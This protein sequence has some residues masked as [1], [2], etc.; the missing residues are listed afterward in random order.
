MIRAEERYGNGD[1]LFDRG[2][3]ESRRWTALYNL[4][5]GTQNFTG[6]PRRCQARLEVDF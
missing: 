1:H 6:T 3:A 4:I 2:R 5:R